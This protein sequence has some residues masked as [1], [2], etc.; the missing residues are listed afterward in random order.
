MSV[1]SFHQPSISGLAL[2]HVLDLLINDMAVCAG[3]YLLIGR[4]ELVECKFP[5]NHV[6]SLTELG[7]CRCNAHA[8]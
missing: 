2:V 7:P 8:P 6:D 4:Q 1:S 5:A 3:A